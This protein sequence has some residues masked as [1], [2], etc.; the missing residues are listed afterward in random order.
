MAKVWATWFKTQK[1]L[2]SPQLSTGAARHAIQVRY[3]QLKMNMEQENKP[4][5]LKLIIEP[6]EKFLYPVSI[7]ISFLFFFNILQS[8]AIVM[9][10]LVGLA[11]VLFLSAFV[12]FAIYS[13]Q[14]EAD[15]HKEFGMLD[16]LTTAIAPKV[17]FI[18]SSVSVFGLIMY[19]VNP[20][21]ESYVRMAM[22]GGVSIT[23]CL[24]IYLV[25]FI[26][27]QKFYKPYVKV[28]S[29]GLPILLL[30]YLLLFE[31]IHSW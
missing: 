31:T 25:G 14:E 22:I 13:S 20:S 29:R 16:L 23:I 1:I 5:K 28:L 30:D 2:V 12:P 8:Q 15:E 10:T 26:S 3:Q 7:V 4:S 27:G 9:W 21:L 19:I 24:I 6:L 11:I 17:V 18:S